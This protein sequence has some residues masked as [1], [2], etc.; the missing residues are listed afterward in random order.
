MEYTVTEQSQRILVD[1]VE[2]SSMHYRSR[3]R[4]SWNSRLLQ[5]PVSLD[6][7]LSVYCCRKCVRRLN[8]VDK[9]IEKMKYLA[10]SSYSKPFNFSPLS[11]ERSKKEAKDTSD[12]IATPH[13]AHWLVP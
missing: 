2:L 4:S 3:E 10:N 6:D 7:G 8:S 11:R 1:Y 9:T 5:L 13:T 12:D